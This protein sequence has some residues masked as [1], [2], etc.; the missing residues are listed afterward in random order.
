MS[1]YLYLGV[2]KRTPKYIAKKLLKR[3]DYSDTNVCKQLSLKINKSPLYNK[4]LPKII[5]ALLSLKPEMDVTYFY[6]QLIMLED[7]CRFDGNLKDYQ[8]IYYKH[9][10]RNFQLKNNI[11]EFLIKYPIKNGLDLFYNEDQGFI[12]SEWVHKNYDVEEKGKLYIVGDENQVRIFFSKMEKV[13]SQT[14]CVHKANELF[15]TPVTIISPFIL[16][17]LLLNKGESNFGLRLSQ[18]LNNELHF[19]EL[20]DAIEAYGT[21]VKS[22]AYV[23]RFS[24]I[25]INLSFNQ[26]DNYVRALIYFYKY[27]RDR[28]H[29][30]NSLFNLYQSRFA[31]NGGFNELSTFLN[32]W[33]SLCGFTGLE[34]PSYNHLTGFSK[35]IEKYKE[36][37]ESKDRSSKIKYIEQ[38]LQDYQKII[39]IANNRFPEDIDLS[40]LLNHSFIRNPSLQVNFNH[41]LNMSKFLIDKG[42]SLSSDMACLFSDN[43]PDEFIY[44]IIEYYL[45]CPVQRQSIVEFLKLEDSV[46]RR[47]AYAQNSKAHII[48]DIILSHCTTNRHADVCRFIEDILIF[49]TQ[50]SLE[51]LK[52]ILTKHNFKIDIEFPKSFTD[53]YKIENST[54][55]EYESVLDIN[56]PYILNKWRLFFNHIFI[57]SRLSFC[58]CD[59][60]VTVSFLTKKMNSSPDILKLNQKIDFKDLEHVLSRIDRDSEFSTFYELKRNGANYEQIQKEF[61]LAVEQSIKQKV[62]MEA[63]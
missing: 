9:K 46:N 30:S 63:L 47:S 13:S 37:L 21:E 3:Y 28:N 54:A 25:F 10:K 58:Y 34:A 1:I 27:S 19:N 59:G 11:T 43:Y 20:F 57:E 42:A 2:I 61:A 32:F 4:Q 26:I 55:S 5:D 22:E 49:N 15:S 52:S 29:E 51:Q 40:I 12:S 41:P 23:R 8:K 39:E 24:E 45:K 36:L 60:K 17:L 50:I 31:D 33:Y 56:G 7:N 14:D 38:E 48:L 53:K 35:K 16:S 44:E 6:A 62:I 18:V